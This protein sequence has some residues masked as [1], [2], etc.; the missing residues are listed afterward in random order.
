[1]KNNILNNKRKKIILSIC[2]LA[3]ITGIIC[4]G[5]VM[6]SFNDDQVAVA[7]YAMAP[8]ISLS[9]DSVYSSLSF[10][11]DSLCF[12]KDAGN[13]MSSFINE[14]N[15]LLNGKDTVINIV[16]LGDSHIQAG[17]LSGR[18]MRLLQ[19]SFG[20]AGRGWIAP[21]RLSK[22][23][24]PPDYFILSNV[25]EWIA[26]RCV[27]LKPKCPWGIGGIGIQTQ[28]KD[29]NFNL[30][31]AP[32]NGAGYSF[33]KVL[34][35]RDINSA[36][37]APAI[38]GNDSTR[39]FSLGNYHYDKIAIDTIM[40]TSLVDTLLI[41]SEKNADNKK[42]NPNL[43]YGFMLMNGNP[44]ILYHSIGVNGAK[45]TDY[46]DRD[47]IRQLAL[48]NPSL[49]I[50]SLGTNESIV[51]NFNKA[52]FEQQL[53][54]FIRLVR[55]EIPGVSLLITTP[56]ESYRQVTVN[57]QRQ[58]VRNENV[59]KVAEIISSYTEKEGLA[60]WDLY[61]IAGGD[62]SCKNWFDAKMFGRDRIHF[63]SNGYDEQ[64][65]LLYKAIVRSYI[66]GQ[67][68]EEHVTDVEMAEPERE[69]LDSGVNI[70][71][72]ADESGEEAHDVE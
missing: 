44:G 34:L 17:Y 32:K 12:I 60:C 64:G 46:T 41:K 67:M 19:N 33:N 8:K 52:L 50:V 53:N 48:L 55:E 72:A 24:E 70:T 11:N 2:G 65:M 56:A 31:M 6:A 43:Y 49:L 37:M 59:A 20:N 25:R 18:T 22:V 15:E 27:Q 63:S 54:A 1:M 4:S 68:P 45:Y 40:T 47:Y 66:S 51:R 58:Y 36:P 9:I 35:Y 30:I 38:I 71:N 42:N 13:S 3:F 39:S 5:K 69:V 14:L 28:A 61:S 7:D 21:F 29:I 62:N 23:N 57:K 16:H 26:G 10:I